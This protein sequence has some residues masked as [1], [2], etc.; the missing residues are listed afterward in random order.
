MQSLAAILGNR[1][2][3][4]VIGVNIMIE[5]MIAAGIIPGHAC[6]RVTIL[7]ILA[8]GIVQSI[9]KAEEGDRVALH[10]GLCKRIRLHGHLRQY[11][12]GTGRLAL[13]VGNHNRIGAKLVSLQVAQ[14]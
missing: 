11:R 10:D 6:N 3:N 14:T 7:V 1:P 12:P 8:G 9:I 4:L 2:L 13:G 5:T